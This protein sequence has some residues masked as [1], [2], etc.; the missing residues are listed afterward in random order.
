MITIEEMLRNGV[1]IGH[2]VKQWN[3]KMK[4]YIFAKRKN[5]YVLDLVQTFIC[6]TKVCN[7]LNNARNNNKVCDISI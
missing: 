6:L 4:R 7:F 2:N 1:H 3:P 5:N